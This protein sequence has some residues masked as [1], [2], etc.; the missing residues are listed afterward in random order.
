V[1]AETSS[2]GLKAHEPAV[3]GAWSL[4]TQQ[5][6]RDLP[7]GRPRGAGVD[8]FQASPR[9]P[10]GASPPERVRAIE[11]SGTPTAMRSRRDP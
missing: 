7:V 9:G 2:A 3:A 10:D 8:V 6:G 1:R 11:R 4:K 5:L